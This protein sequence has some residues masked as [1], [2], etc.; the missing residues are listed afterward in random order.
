M[1]RHLSRVGGARG[2]RSPQAARRDHPRIAA[3]PRVHRRPLSDRARLEQLLGLQHALLL[4]ARAALRARRH[5]R[6][7]S[8]DRVATARRR[9]RDRPRR[10]LQPHG[11]R[12]SS[13]ADAELPRHRQHL[14]LPAAARST[15]LLRRRHRLWERA[16]S[17]APARAAD[18]DGLVAL[19]GRGLSCRW[20]P[21]RSCEHARSRS[22]RLRPRR[23]LLCGGPARPRAGGRQADRRALGPRRGRLPGRQLS[24]RLVGV[25]RRVSPHA[26]PLLD[27]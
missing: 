19:L 21:V 18:G 16:Q 27:G 9:H 13:G 2:H 15:T 22:Q 1:A 26:A 25:E 17:H 5:A 8:L 14:V 23:R 11:R 3:D 12:Q 6:R 24:A 7:L 20:F 10:G 4:R